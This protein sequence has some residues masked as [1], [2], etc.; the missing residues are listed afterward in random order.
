MLWRFGILDAG[1]ATQQCNSADGLLCG[2][3]LIAGIM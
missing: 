1:T 2:P 3:P